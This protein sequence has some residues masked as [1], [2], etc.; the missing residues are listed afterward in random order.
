MW[1]MERSVPILERRAPESRLLALFY[2]WIVSGYIYR[3]YRHGLRLHHIE[4]AA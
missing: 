4:E 2:R 3:G 1:A